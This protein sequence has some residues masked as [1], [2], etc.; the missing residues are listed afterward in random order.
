MKKI[1]SV[2]LCLLLIVSVKSQ[3]N[4]TAQLQEL[5][6]NQPSVQNQQVTATLK[7]ASRL[8][9][10]K[11]DL[12]SVILIIPSGSVVAVRE[13]NDSTY[14]KVTFEETDGYIFKRDAIIN[15]ATVQITVP[16]QQGNN[17]QVEQPLE[18]QQVSRFSYLES[19]YGTKMATRLASGKIWKG[20]SAGMVDDSWGKPVKINR[21]IGDVVKEE[22]IYK[23]TWLYIENNVLVEWG[24]ITK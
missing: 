17:Q 11:Q 9:G 12:T 18:Q 3:V 14:L 5:E 2:V 23:N 21:V 4:K 13:Q 1:I 19:K 16:I 8:F 22:W 24:A 7:S 10:S 15:N 6:K 20:M